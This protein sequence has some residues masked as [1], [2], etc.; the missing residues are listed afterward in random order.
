[1]NVEIEGRAVFTAEVELHL[2][3]LDLQ[4]MPLHITGTFTKLPSGS[5]I[6]I[7][8]AQHL[9]T[10]DR[11]NSGSSHLIR[12]FGRDAYRFVMTDSTSLAFAAQHQS[13]NPATGKPGFA[14]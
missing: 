9:L 5:E 7:E 12:F 11:R 13:I 10:S 14:R 4:H 6:D 2:D 8:L 1:M 3:H